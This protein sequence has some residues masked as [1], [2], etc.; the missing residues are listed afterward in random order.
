MKVDAQKN[1]VNDGK[2]QSSQKPPKGLAELGDTKPNASEKYNDKA[3]HDK[4]RPCDFHD[5]PHFSRRASW[6]GYPAPVLAPPDL[7]VRILRFP[8]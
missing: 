6:V 4:N 5:I 1:N 8:S 2:Q 7:R 3:N